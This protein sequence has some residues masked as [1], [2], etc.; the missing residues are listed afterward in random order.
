MN[1]KVIKLCLCVILG[2]QAAEVKNSNS[3]A[4]N[5]SK[6]ADNAKICEQRA[7]AL[8]QEALNHGNEAIKHVNEKAQILE[9]VHKTLREKAGFNN[10]HI[11]RVDNLEAKVQNGVATAHEEQEHTELSNKISK[12]ETNVKDFAGGKL[13]AEVSAKVPGALG[14]FRAFHDHEIKIKEHTDNAK[15]AMEASEQAMEASN[16]LKR[17][18]VRSSLAPVVDAAV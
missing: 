3:V 4:M 6:K 7:K 15:K 18:A 1:N 8:A 11:D 9:E 14:L 16:Q 2:A 13:N 17:E 12:V 10:V 5:A